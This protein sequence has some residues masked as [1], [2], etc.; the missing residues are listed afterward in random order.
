MREI[1]VFEMELQDYDESN[2]IDVW[3]LPPF[4]LLLPSL[5]SH[6]LWDMITTN[7]GISLEIWDQ[8]VDSDVSSIT[9]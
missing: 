5:L 1:G 3:D 9:F 7:E 8:F 4:S 2:V 6:T